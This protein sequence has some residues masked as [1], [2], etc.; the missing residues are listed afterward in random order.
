MVII[1]LFRYIKQVS[2]KHNYLIIIDNKIDYLFQKPSKNF[3]G[4][5]CNEIDCPNLSI[6]ALSKNG[7]TSIEQFMGVSIKLRI[8][9]LVIEFENV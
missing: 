9:Y 2:I 3:D 4:N 5:Y 6:L 7:F 8:L 1:Q